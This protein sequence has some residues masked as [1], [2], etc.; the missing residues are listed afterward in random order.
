MATNH[1]DSGSHKE[2]LNIMALTFWWFYNWLFIPQ[3]TAQR[4]SGDH[5]EAAGIQ[6]GR[7]CDAVE[8]TSALDTSLDLNPDLPFCNYMSLIKQVT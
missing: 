8:G 3:T 2:L 7:E 6:V 5:I 4:K 1:L